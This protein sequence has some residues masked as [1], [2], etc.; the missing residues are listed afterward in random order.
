MET[1]IDK[2]CR[3]CYIGKTACVKVPDGV[4]ALAGAKDGQLIYPLDNDNDF[5]YEYGHNLIDS[6]D[7]EFMYEIVGVMEN[8]KVTIMPENCSRIYN[9]DHT[10]TSFSR[11]QLDTLSHN[12]RNI[13]EEKGLLKKNELYVKGWFYFDTDATDNDAA[14]EEFRNACEEIGINAD[15]ITDAVIRD[16][17]GNDLV[18]VSH[19]M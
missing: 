7:D 9:E 2:S 1:N 19:Y 12:I 16:S 18:P 17:D 6:E 11:E 5:M 4:E 8:G 14:I 10:P 3:L 15:N 13:F